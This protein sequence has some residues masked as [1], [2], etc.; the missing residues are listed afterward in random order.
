MKLIKLEIKALSYSE[1]QSGAYAMIL[2]EVGGDRKLPIII[3]GFE[4]QSI[5]IALDGEIKTK[6]PL[7]HDLF[8][9]FSSE[10]KISLQKILI[11]KLEDGVFHSNLFFNYNNSEKIIDARTS[12]AVALAIRFDAPI[13]TYESIMKIAG[14]NSS[15]SEKNKNISEK[16]SIE[17][18]INKKEFSLE[19]LKNLSP[20]KLKSL[21][22]R[23][24]KSENYETAAIIR[25]EILKRE[26]K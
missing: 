22:K 25:D 14:F 12:D 23:F 9:N 7:T 3:G 6:R 16:D 15:E 5:A 26:L 11:N 10:F 18:H 17:N 2:N 24:V 4:A 19:D 1:T 8:K 20:S 21:L 13:Y